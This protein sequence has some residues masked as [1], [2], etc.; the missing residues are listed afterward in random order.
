MLTNSLIIV[1]QF[2]IVQFCWKRS[3]ANARALSAPMP[4]PPAVIIATLVML[5]SSC[6]VRTASCTAL[7]SLALRP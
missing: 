1:P 6:A 2:L 7:M 5:Y 4:E 3:A